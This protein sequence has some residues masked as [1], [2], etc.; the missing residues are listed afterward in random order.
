M[1]K[2]CGES[3]QKVGVWER[4]REIAAETAEVK[5]KDSPRL[6]VGQDGVRFSSADTNFVL[7]LGAHIQADGRFFIGDH[8]PVNDTFLLRRVRPIFE[9]TVFKD[10]DYRLMLDFGANTST[11]STVQ[12]AYIN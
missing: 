11:A 8:I 1:R 9:G 12:D 7:K 3:E 2:R 10:I 4:N 5:K 6:T